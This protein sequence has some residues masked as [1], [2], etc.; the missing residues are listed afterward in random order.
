MTTL[1]RFHLYVTRL[2]AAPEDGQA[3][4]EYALVLLGVAAIAL[5]VVA[6]ATHSD[7]VGKLLNAVFDQLMR[8]V[9]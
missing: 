6:W 9:K 8:R 1:I 5:M 7:R 4:A 3:T 2:L